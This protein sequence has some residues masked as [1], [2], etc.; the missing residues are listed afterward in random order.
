VKVIGVVN[1]CKRR[2]L[3]SLMFAD[4]T[5]SAAAVPHEAS[6]HWWPRGRAAPR[7]RQCAAGVQHWPVVVAHLPDF[8]RREPYFNSKQSVESPTSPMFT[9]FVTDRLSVDG[10]VT[11]IAGTEGDAP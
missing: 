3:L 1:L 5:I 4:D 11:V 6:R 8:A 2:A 9:I 10:K 7:P